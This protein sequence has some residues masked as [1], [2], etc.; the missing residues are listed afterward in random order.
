MSQKQVE[1]E[2]KMERKSFVL[3]VV[4]I[5]LIG[6]FSVIASVQQVA[7]EQITLKGVTF[8][9]RHLLSSASMQ[10]LTKRVYERSKGELMIQYLGGPEAMAPNAQIE[11]VRTGR[12]DIVLHSA[13][14]FEDIVPE[15][16]MSHVS[17]LTPMEERKNGGYE[18]FAKHLKEKLNV[19]YLGRASSNVGWWVHTNFPVEK[20]ADLERKQIAA[21]PCCYPFLKAVGAIPISV[22]KGDWYSAVERGV[23]KGYALP[24][25]SVVSWGLTKITKYTIVH[26]FYKAS[27][28]FFMVNLQKWNSLPPKDQALMIKIATELESEAVDFRGK[29]TEDARRKMK[30]DGVKF[31]EFS[32]A[33]KKKMIDL[34]NGAAWEM[35]K[36][37]VSPEIYAE[38]RK[39]FTK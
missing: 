6:I 23:V 24:L 22:G 29:M 2:D 36:K 15:V 21:R 11:A 4:N 7:A 20:V 10:S 35:Y 39:L 3:W 16:S 30:E 13:E 32:P 27:N 31:I 1:K 34:A 26:S 8:L 19:F 38:A 5:I 18:W 33:E 17:E 9:P 28:I 37:K 25:D 14:R 12:I